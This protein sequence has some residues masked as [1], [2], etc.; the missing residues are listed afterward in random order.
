MGAALF[1]SVLVDTQR[2]AV[3]ASFRPR[4]PSG[5]C[6][7]DTYMRKRAPKMV[8]QAHESGYFFRP[9]R[10]LGCN[11]AAKHSLQYHVLGSSEPSAMLTQAK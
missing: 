8:I 7:I 6:H 1:R 11:L 4:V 3:L 9:L 2:R 10:D 5:K